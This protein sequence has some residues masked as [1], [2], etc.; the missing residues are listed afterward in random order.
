MLG[1]KSF[2]TAAVTFSGVELAHRIRKCQFTL[3]YER[4]GRALSLG[5]FPYVP[6]E[7]AWARRHAARHFLE[8][9]VDPASQ[10]EALRRISVDGV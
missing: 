1:L 3:A 8:A 10:R 9:G 2:H 7:S 5:H 6:L 4:K